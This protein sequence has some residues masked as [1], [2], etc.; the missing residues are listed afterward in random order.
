MDAKDI[1]WVDPAVVPGAAHL[2]H[3]SNV[4]CV[5]NDKGEVAVYKMGTGPRDANSLQGNR[6]R[7]IAERFVDQYRKYGAVG[8]KQ[9]PHVFLPDSPGRY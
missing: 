6:H 2:L 3:H 8:V 5:V 1:T 4:W 7:S 9:I